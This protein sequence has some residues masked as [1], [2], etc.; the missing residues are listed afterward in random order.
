MHKNRSCILWITW[1]DWQSVWK[2][3]TRH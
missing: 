1:L 3:R 2:R